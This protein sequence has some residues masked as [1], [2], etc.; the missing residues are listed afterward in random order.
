MFKLSFQKFS[1]YSIQIFADADSIGTADSI[2]CGDAFIISGQSNSIT[3]RPYPELSDSVNEWIR[4]YGNAPGVSWNGWGLAQGHNMS[5]G[6]KQGPSIGAWGWYMANGLVWKYKVPVCIINGGSGGT[7]IKSHLR[8]SNN[9]FDSYSLYSNHLSR[10][11]NSG[12]R[13]GIKA[14]IWHQG[15]SDSDVSRYPL[16][17]ARL[18]SLYHSWKMDYPALKHIYIFQIRPGCGGLR[19]AEIR[20]IQRTFPGSRTDIHVMSTNG[21][22]GHSYQNDFCHY[23]GTGYRQMASWIRALLERDFY[24][25][26]DTLAIEPPDVVSAYHTSLLRNQIAVEFT[27]PV[28][29]NGALTTR[30]WFHS[31]KSAFQVD[32]SSANVKSVS[33]DSVNSRILVN[34]TKSLSATRISYLPELYY[35]DTNITYE[36][37]W[38]VN[39]RGVGALAFLQFP[40]TLPDSVRDTTQIFADT[41]TPDSLSLTASSLLLLPG[42]SIRPD[43]VGYF[44][45]LRR[46][47][48]TGLSWIS[49]SVGT[50][51][52]S[53]EG[54]LK[55]VT[56]GG[57]VAVIVGKKGVYDTVNVTVKSRPSILKRINFEDQNQPVLPDWITENWGRYSASRG[58]GWDSFPGA[59]HAY[60]GATIGPWVVRTYVALGTGNY[61]NEKN[62]WARY[63]IQVPAGDYVLRIGMGTQLW[64]GIGGRTRDIAVHNGDTLVNKDFGYCSVHTMRITVNGDSGLKLNIFGAINYIVLISGE[65]EQYVN[66]FANDST[67]GETPPSL[68][69]TT[70]E[71][72]GASDEFGF[73]G[74]SPNPFNP[75]TSIRF[76]LPTHVNSV[77]TICDVQGRE[78][79]RT[80]VSHAGAHVIFWNG[81]DMKGQRVASG[82]YVG[83]LQTSNGYKKEHRL[84]MLK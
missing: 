45:G 24:G 12:L 56:E 18:D 47:V 21:L 3:V 14:V 52:V 80:A 49:K 81:N 41:A 66:L 6:A 23:E 5:T 61:G 64:M 50:V 76:N 83:R 2:V 71:I 25:S 1:E 10:T 84:I 59:G 53:S 30:N 72:D 60:H 57:P 70:G 39:S 79:F 77:Y 65:F 8:N 13:G 58:F 16:Y 74:N 37:P 68:P 33:W 55:G 43:V 46:P 75:S 48:I 4:S 82:L 26:A 34:L 20:E 15:E 22:T 69:Y 7:E 62:A 73:K 42:D 28:N 67:G 51:T 32:S 40:V 19:G 63:R 27:Q 78:I 29:W 54:L 31:I 38:L 11:T 35:P 36:G 9:P 17:A 44:N